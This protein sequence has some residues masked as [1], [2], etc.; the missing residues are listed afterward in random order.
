[1]NKIA[2]LIFLFAIFSFSVMAEDKKS[3]RAI[4]TTEF[5]LVSAGEIGEPWSEVQLLEKYGQPCTIIELGEVFIEK[6]EGHI[7]E[8]DAKTFMQDKQRVSETA[9]KKQF[10]YSGDFSSKT[11]V[12]TIINGVIV[13]KEKIF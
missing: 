6:S 4:D 7:I 9:I 11:S 2:A 12:F 3:C 13:K 1:M 5:G 10:V 8:L